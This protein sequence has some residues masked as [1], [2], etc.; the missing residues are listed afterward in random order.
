MGYRYLPCAS[1]YGGGAE[2][3]EP[4]RKKQEVHQHQEAARVLMHRDLLFHLLP[5]EAQV[6]LRAVLPAVE[7]VVPVIPVGAAVH[8]V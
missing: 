6:N 2:D 7:M 1:W 4:R 3:E 5:V 8:Q